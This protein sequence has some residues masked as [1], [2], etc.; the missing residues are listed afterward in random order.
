M[1]KSVMQDFYYGK[2]VLV[3]GGAGFIGSH[4]VELLVARGARVTV[5]V[6]TTTEVKNLAVV[7]NRIRIVEADLADRAAIDAVMQGQEIVFDLCMSKRG[8]IAQ[9]AQH[10]ASMFRD[11]MAPFLNV[12]E[13]A[14]RGG[15]ERMLVMSSA[16]VY[17]RESAIPI[18]ES[19]GFKDA[20]EAGNEGY[21]WAKRMQEYAAIS[22]AQEYGMHVAIMR[23]FNAYGPRDKFFSEHVQVIPAIMRRIARGEDPLVVWGSGKQ[24]RSF[25]YVTDMARAIL[26]ACE[27]YAVADPVNVGGVE[28]VSIGDLARLLIA[29]TGGHTKLIFDTSKP[30]GHP[31]RLPDVQKAQR[32]F[33]FRPAVSLREGLQH[34]VAWFNAERARKDR[35]L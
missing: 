8:G 17:P 35:P 14:R 10:H 25:I 27:K 20:P 3:T 6:R 33:G 18:P 22:Y 32:A 15:V 9:S 5:P 23:G 21:G 2:C 24:T 11:N 4:V 34:T 26:D 12:I 31:R 13:S 28:E 30:E 19:E 7:Q 29:L 1:P 16:C